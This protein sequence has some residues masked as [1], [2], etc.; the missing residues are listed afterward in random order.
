MHRPHFASTSKDSPTHSTAHR[1]T[2]WIEFSVTQ[3]RRGNNNRLVKRLNFGLATTSLILW[4]KETECALSPVS[5]R[6]TNFLKAIKPA[7][8]LS[9]SSQMKTK[10]KQN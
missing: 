6:H 7:V 4:L 5:H 2:P 8:C 3:S 9:K 1:F 10:W